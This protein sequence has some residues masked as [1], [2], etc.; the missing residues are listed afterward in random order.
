M[1]VLKV[2]AFN[3]MTEYL[4]KAKTTWQEYSV[5]SM[6]DAENRY[7]SQ[8]ILHVLRLWHVR[9]VELLICLFLLI[10]TRKKTSDQMSLN[11]K[12]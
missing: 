7:L 11:T 5:F 9:V 4:P 6:S 10:S 2:C 12:N 1:E 3:L 8:Q